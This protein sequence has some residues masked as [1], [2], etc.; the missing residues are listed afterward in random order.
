[1]KRNTSFKRKFRKEY[2]IIEENKLFSNA[3]SMASS[4]AVSVSHI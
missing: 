1:M 3:L 2:K 4:D